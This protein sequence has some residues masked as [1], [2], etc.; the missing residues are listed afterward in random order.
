MKLSM[1]FI[2]FYVQLSSEK[3]KVHLNGPIYFSVDDEEFGPILVGEFRLK[4]TLEFKMQ[5][6]KL[7]S[8]INSDI[9]HLKAESH[10]NHK[11]MN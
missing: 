6:L 5:N 9:S 8:K 2:P 10:L 11:D 1:S 4:A 7:Y 3:D